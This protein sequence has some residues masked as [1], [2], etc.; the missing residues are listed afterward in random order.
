[1][2]SFLDNE[3]RTSEH[4]IGASQSGQPIPGVSEAVFLTKEQEL[5]TREAIDVNI[6]QEALMS[7][8]SVDGRPPSQR[9]RAVGWKW[10]AI[11]VPVL[12]LGGAVCMM[13]LGATLG[14]VIGVGLA[15]VLFLF[16]GGWPVWAAGLYRG[17]EESVA[18]K[19]ALAELHR[20]HMH[21]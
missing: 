7:I 19:E 14:A 4:T 9:Q 2:T 21:R 12:F 1:M 16:L 17:K 6:R 20:V 11:G 10:I 8:E 5:T 3:R 13:I 18:R 15:C